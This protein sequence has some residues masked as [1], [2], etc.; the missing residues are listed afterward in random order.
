MRSIYPLRSFIANNGGTSVFIPPNY[1]YTSSENQIYRSCLVLSSGKP[2]R[3]L[4][5]QSASGNMVTSGNNMVTALPIDD[6]D[7]LRA[8]TLSGRL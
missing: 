2:I 8:N 7:T 4:N 5:N 6:L 3:T 1:T